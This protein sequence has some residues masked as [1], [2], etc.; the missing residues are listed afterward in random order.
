MS[1]QQPSTPS[2]LTQAVMDALQQSEDGSW[3]LKT[4]SLENVHQTFSNVVSKGSDVAIPQIRELASF[5][6]FLEKEAG[7]KKA[8]EQIFQ[9]INRLDQ[10]LAGLGI[11][12]KPVEDTQ[13]K[14]SRFLGLGPVS[15]PG[16]PSDSEAEAPAN[17]FKPWAR[18]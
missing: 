12:V 15:L 9:V 7:S 16:L 2:E 8:V 11:E 17:T 3:S 13:L 1:A 18:H 5:A 6:M 4:S 10:V 14:A